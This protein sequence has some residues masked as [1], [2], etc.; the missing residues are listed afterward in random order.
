M[1]IRGQT[2][3]EVYWFLVWATSFDIIGKVPPWRGYASFSFQDELSAVTLRHLDISVSLLGAVYT[4]E[5]FT[6]LTRDLDGTS[7]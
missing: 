4:Y 2:L 1:P 7:T 3:G 5:T 6:L